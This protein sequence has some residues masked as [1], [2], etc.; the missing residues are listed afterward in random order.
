MDTDLEP[1]MEDE[2]VG[3]LALGVVFY[4]V[5]AQMNDWKNG[6]NST[7]SAFDGQTHEHMKDNIT[8]A[9]LYRALFKT[10]FMGRALS[11]QDK[12]MDI[13]YTAWLLQVNRVSDDF[14]R[15]AVQEKVN[16]Y[17]TKFPEYDRLMQKLENK[18]YR[19]EAA[20]T[21]GYVEAGS[22]M[23]TELTLKAV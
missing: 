13:G 3:A 14:K 10:A 18:G 12:K 6:W 22:S 23:A 16:E 17:L 5:A 1:K 2:N 15:S 11:G 19:V 21:R 7:F 4:T 8:K 20:H 9:A